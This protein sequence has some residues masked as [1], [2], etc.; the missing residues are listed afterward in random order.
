MLVETQTIRH[1]EDNL[2]RGQVVNRTRGYFNLVFSVITLSN[3][4]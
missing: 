4:M 2:W 1:H 3:T